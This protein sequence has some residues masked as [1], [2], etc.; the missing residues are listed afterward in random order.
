F[1]E[2]VTSSTI[3]F[4]LRGPGGTAVA[5]ATSYDAASRTATFDPG[6]NLATST[7]YTASISGARDASGNQMDP[8]SWSFTT[9]ATT[10]GCPCTIWPSTTTPAGTDPDT[11]SVELG[12]KFRT[13]TAGYITG[14][15]YWKPT[16]T[17]GTHVGSFWTRTG[18]RLGQVTFT[19]ESASGWQ[20]A[21]FAS[22]I[23]VN[24]NTTYVA[25]YFTPTRYAVNGGYFSTATTRGPLTALQN[26]TDG[27]N[28]TYRYTSTP[29]TFPDQSFNSENY[30]VD[31]VFEDGPD[32][33]KPTVTARTPAPGATGVSVGGNVTGTFSE[34]VEGSSATVELRAPGGS[35]VPGETTYDTAT[36]TVTLD[37]TSALTAS[38][39]Y[40]AT[41][42]GATDT[43]GNQMDP[44]SW[45]FTA[46][47]A[48]TTSPAVT[49][50]TPAVGATNVA[51]T[52]NATATFSEAVTSSTIT[53]ELRGPGGT[54]VAGAT[55]YDAA[56]R[57]AT[58]DPGSNL[59]TSTTYTASISGARDASGNQ[60]DPV[61]WSFTTT[62]TTSG[63]PCTIWPSTTTPAGTDPD[64]SSVELGVKFRTSTAGYITGIRYWKPTQTSGTHVG[65]F[66]TR[67]GTRLGQVTF[68]NESASG[69]QEATFASPIPVN[70]NTTYVA[71][72]FTP[73]RYAVNGGYF[74]T[75]TTRGPLTALQ[76]GTDGGN[77]TYRYT[78]TPSTFPDQS[79][80]SENYWVDVVF[81]EQANDTIPPT[82]VSRVPAGNATGVAVGVRASATFNELVT[83]SSV[84]M[85]LKT[86]GGQVVPSTTSYDAGTS[87]ATV[88]PAADL[89]YTSTYTVEVSG[90]R[91]SAGNTMAPVSWSFQTAGEPPP[92]IGDGPGGPIGVVTSSGNPSSTYL[93]EIIRAEGLNEFTNVRVSTLNATSLA[94]YAVVVLGDVAITDAQVTALTDWV[95]AGGNL[96]A[97][98][99][100]SRLYG[101]AGIT[102]QAGTVADGYLAVNPAAEPGAGITTDTMQ[103]HGTASRYTLNGAA[104][105]A[106][107]YSNATTSTGLPA[108]TL[109]SVGTNGGQVATFA[110][111]LA[112]SV[113][114]TRQGNVAWAGQDR[115]GATP[116][117][118]N[119]LFFG[120]SG[121]TDWVNLS[122]AHI[123]QAD[124]QQRLLANLV[125][126][127]TRDRLPVPRFWYFPGT[128]R[129]VVVATGDDHGNNGTP[130]RFS[131]YAA[132]SPS[133]CSVANWECP[134]FTSY[135][136]PSTAMTNSQA[137]TF[138][139]QG[140]E[141]GI[142]VQNNCTNFGS[143][144]QLA[145]TYT[146]Q[147]ST[148]RTKYNSLP[149]PTT[150]RYH[151]IVWSDWVSQP[152]AEL[153]NGMRLDTNYYYY[154]GSWV[155]DRPGF[156]NG[157]GMP[158]RFTDTDGS[159]IDVF[160]AN[161]NMTDESGQTY[162]FTPNTLLD[163][164]LGSQGYYGAFTANLHTDSASTFEDTQVLASAQARNVPVITA[165]Q[166]LTWTD[167]RNASSFSGIS[168]SGNT[169]SFTI[170]V[171]VGATGLTAMLPTTGPGGST[172]TTVT[173][174]STSVPFTTMTVK[175][176]QYA[177][178]PAIG[179][180]HQ[181]TYAG[182]GG[183][184]GGGANRVSG[185]AVT[186]SDTGDTTATW[187][188][189]QPG[190]SVVLLGTAPT[191]L[192]TRVAL[193]DR[194]TD[195][196]A[197][198]GNLRPATRYYYRVQSR[199]PGGRHTVWPAAHAAPAS[200]VTAA[201]DRTAPRVSRLRVLPLPDGSARVTWRTNEPAT[202]VVRLGRA[203]APLRRRGFD[204]TL[205]RSHTVVVTGL[206]ARRA[207][208]LRVASRDGSGNAALQRSSRFR[209]P[210]VGIAMMTAE[211]FRTGSLEG[212][213]RVDD[214]GLGGL[215][216][217]VRGWGRYTSRVVDSGRKAR[218]HG[219][220]LDANAPAGSQI[221]VRV[222]AGDRATP[223]G[224]WS[225]WKVVTRPGS[226]AE[227]SGRYVQYDVTLAA[228]QGGLPSVRAVGLTR[229]GGSPRHAER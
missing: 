224:A 133:G 102:A 72:Y 196:L 229:T 98:R 10:S 68:T 178:F 210:G 131:T 63:C 157:S 118:S 151:C 30:W 191:A 162:P 139:S 227:V 52:A 204:S 147:L 70:A 134:R 192:S 34:P 117:R 1:S 173:R 75:A 209:T 207:Y 142:H 169:L 104:S 174:G 152:K 12:V 64:T 4:E 90:A 59:A 128:H 46:E 61:S 223:D 182:G 56:S 153:A 194:T 216:L 125:T 148:W 105:V 47:A 17:S 119:D 19:N 215:T 2:A 156:M 164:A 135:I 198:L 184:G 51:T 146:S 121:A 9:T 103:F 205:S 84:S 69:W 195:H 67:T 18:T 86:A 130:G 171:G 154:P 25:S 5:G 6:S 193:A 220:V 123:P 42:R 94:S 44:V 14:I 37:P 97:M 80:N 74:S 32:T 45:S 114:A 48:D 141:V 183:G 217:G 127:T 180:A 175:G 167:G 22:P 13:S 23:P 55:S 166:L 197:A 100:D 203:G 81:S 92:G 212:D 112:R 58:F 76:N 181:A 49:G 219:L 33:T 161:T 214:A 77:G 129:A 149:S 62:A 199:G 7:T 177:V 71:S 31:V 66:W 186:T 155:A 176:Q 126:V 54:A 145:D 83:G 101:L 179:G 27:G 85:V 140:F 78:S 8:V 35:V 138:D 201:V 16:Q 158:M 53:F 113:I 57:T 15:R 89:A 26:G 29:S 93:S 160:Q 190:T 202:S 109:R 143:Y 110:F 150:N 41:L 225:D 111:D 91:D 137:A 24:A 11:S 36:R 96:I 211:D 60:M 218:W 132:A 82:I 28:G 122:K 43:A 116:N 208:S 99:P 40:T 189:E 213:L 88:T 95:N 136:F 120:G 38:A 124:E 159:M 39:T 106:T 21:T 115:D 79:F 87:T 3:T 73:T 188:T 226:R 144:Q 163:R 222:R 187:T 108:V 206:L 65:S 168:W 200:F 107:L 221:V 20:E 185:A 170:G 165:R 50:R 228:A 172:L